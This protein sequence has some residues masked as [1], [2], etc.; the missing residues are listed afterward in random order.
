MIE[1][2]E[3]TLGNLGLGNLSEIPLLNLFATAHSHGLVQ[4]RERTLAEVAD[5]KGRVLYPAYYMTHLRVPE[6]ALLQRH[7][8]WDTVTVGVDIRSYG[9]MLLDSVCV[10]GAQGELGEDPGGWDL[11]ARPSMRASSMF[12]LAE[13]QGEQ[14][15]A[16][17]AP[18]QLAPL[19]QL[20]KPPDSME[21]FRALQ[22]GAALRPEFR[23]RLRSERPHQME[24]TLWRDA[25]PGRNM[26][27][28][29]FSEFAN[30]AEDAL[31]TQDVW[32]RFPLNLLACAALL[33]RETYYF[34]NCRADETVEVQ[35]MARFETCPPELET[36]S[37]DLVAAGLLTFVSELYQVPQNS[38]LAV[39]A[40]RKLLAVPSGQHTTLRD[41]ERLLVQ[42]GD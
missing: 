2:V 34:G 15:L 28:S 18:K 39:C 24:V 42:H 11:D 8:L 3:L 14:Q 26:M 27:F 13:R 17:P 9:G 16:R 38:L 21:R 32:P 23:G 25:A 19:P 37:S 5:A 12:V 36:G 41:A 10:L 33:E 6:H 30:L 7:K 4:G 20:G 22:S 1:N 35:T 31:L 40:A 29:K